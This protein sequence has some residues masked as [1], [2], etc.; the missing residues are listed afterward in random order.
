MAVACWTAADQ[1]NDSRRGALWS[2]VATHFADAS[3]GFGLHLDQMRED[4][5]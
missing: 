5:A 4:S 2:L 3:R 1:T